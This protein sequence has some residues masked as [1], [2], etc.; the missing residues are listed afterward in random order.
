MNGKRYTEEIKIAAVKQVAERWHPVAEVAQRLGVS[1]HSHYTWTQCDEMPEEKRK[2]VDTQADELRRL[3]AELKRVTKERNMLK[4]SRRVLRQDVRVR[5]AFIVELQDRFPYGCAFD[6]PLAPSAQ[7]Y[8]NATFFRLLKRNESGEN[9]R[10]TWGSKT[11]RIRLYR[12]VLQSEV[13]AQ[14]Q[15]WHVAGRVRETVFSTAC[16]LLENSCRFNSTQ[17]YQ[18]IKH[19]AAISGAERARKI[20]VTLVPVQART[21]QGQRD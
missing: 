21:A 10:L 11:G 9:L 6:G 4:K 17:T 19:P 18:G 3:K 15:P 16:E 20:V 14:L 5:Y 7:E 8:G 2:A 12:D 13:S 1:A